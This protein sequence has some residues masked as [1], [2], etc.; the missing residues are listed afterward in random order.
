MTYRELFEAVCVLAPADKS[1]SVDIETWRY[2]HSNGGSVRVTWSIYIADV[3]QWKAPDAA[4][5]YAAFKE[6]TLASRQL[7][8][9][10]AAN[11]VPA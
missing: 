5:V 7:S 8:D 2:S 11:E 6:S 9:L 10:E 3:G 4:S 1:V